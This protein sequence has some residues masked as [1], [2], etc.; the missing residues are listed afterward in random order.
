MRLSD[1]QGPRKV[2]LSPAGHGTQGMGL[3]EPLC[4]PS[5]RSPVKASPRVRVEGSNKKGEPCPQ[6]A[7]NG[8]DPASKQ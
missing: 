8:V 7:A 4:H 1:W 5:S 3:L 2:D 6:G